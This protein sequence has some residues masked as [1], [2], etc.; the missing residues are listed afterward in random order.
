MVRQQQARRRSTTHRPPR[1]RTLPS[2]RQLAVTSDDEVES[3]ESFFAN[4]LIR[5]RAEVITDHMVR[6]VALEELFAGIDVVVAQINDAGVSAPVAAEEAGAA[7][8]AATSQPVAVSTVVNHSQI[9][10]PYTETQVNLALA[11]I[12]A[13]SEVVAVEDPADWSAD[14][15]GDEDVV[16]DDVVEQDQ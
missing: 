14:D 1:R 6:M 16:F 5:I 15:E 13:S 3:M 2:R 12:Q 4:S 8:Q 10:E 7:G 9:V 11:Q